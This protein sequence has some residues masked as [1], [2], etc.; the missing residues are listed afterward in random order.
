MQLKIVDE[1][2]VTKASP[3][4][5][6][7]GGKKWFLKHISS[8]L[9]NNFQNYH[10]PFLGG[11]AVFFNTENQKRNYL[12][13]LNEELINTYI[14]IRDNVG[15]VISQLKR[16]KNTEEE[17]YK[18]RS[19]TFKETYAKA[20]QF[21][22]LNMTSFNGI[23]RVNR[24]GN[25]NVPY[26]YRFTIDFVQEDIL[27]LANQKLKNAI[28]KH[29]DFEQSLQVVKKNDFVFIDPPYTVAH[30]NNGF[31]LYNQK[32]F[33]LEDQYRLAECLKKLTSVGAYFIMTNAYHSKI[34]E[35]YKGVG[36][37]NIL[38]RKS[39]IGGKG[40]KRDTIREYI[41]KNY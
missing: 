11:G 19:R 24:Q 28:L 7:A 18:I 8:Q 26:G 6:W 10:E 15:K 41:I 38:D 35:I 13:D 30:E 3:F 31:I 1:P 40:A 9:P 39:L 33:S 12:S 20:A 32:L 22:Y 2:P 21:I 25:Y 5:R 36:S 29:Q 16:F 23:Y 17:Y 4:L 37:F 14:E 27:I 34:N